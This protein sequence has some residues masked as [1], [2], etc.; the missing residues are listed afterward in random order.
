M[1]PGELFAGYKIERRLGRGGMGSV[2][3]AAHPR[4]PRLTALKLLN[5]E[6]FSDNEIRARFEREADL[7]A[8]L[9]HSNVVTVYDRGVEGD[10]PWIAMQYVDGSDAASLDPRRLTPPRAAGIIGDVAAALDYAH[11]K[12]VLHRD[13]KPANMLLE[14]SAAGTDERVLLTDFGIARLHEEQVR[15]TRTGTVTATLAYA[16]P[17]QLSDA[18]LDA[19]TDQ[20]SLACSLFWLLTGAAPF[21]GTNP[22]A[23]IAG[24]LQAPPPE[25]SSARAGLPTAVDA[26]LAKA[27]A[28]RP[29]DRFDS[30]TEFAAAARAAVETPKAVTIP[31]AAGPEPTLRLPDSSVAQP[32]S[33]AAATTEVIAP[34][35]P[36]RRRGASRAVLAGGILGVVVIAAAALVALWPSDNASGGGAPA[37][38]GGGPNSFGDPADPE[39][40]VRAFPK[41]VLQSTDPTRHTGYNNSTCTSE[42]GGH[43]IA[44]GQDAGILGWVAAWKCSGD[45]AKDPD[46]IVYAFQTADAAQAGLR[47]RVNNA[48]TTDTNN[49]KSYTNHR[50]NSEG[51][52]DSGRYYNIVTS[53]ESDPSRANFLVHSSNF[54]RATGLSSEEF[55][56]WWQ[57]LPLAW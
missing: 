42:K 31:M 14:R 54:R 57:N 45:T 27:M 55:D 16:S 50:F 20:Y 15:L 37:A 52:G 35:S 43:D 13:V 33:A 32:D 34:T 30:C 44:A 3:L 11:G 26:V 19:R 46:Y 12:G 28:K 23:V 39:T 8:G 48:G 25:A 1:Q 56:L 4:L 53:F 18:P 2:Y 49:G 9:H 38:R 47:A 36:P 6:L 17:E 7:A 24:H 10:Q 51:Y 22:G 5:R 21:A 40:I 29:E 41:L